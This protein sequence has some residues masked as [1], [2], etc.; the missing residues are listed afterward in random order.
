MK[1]VTVAELIA[2]LQTKPQHL[3]VCFAKYSEYQLL[4]LEKNDED[5]NYIQIKTLQPPRA[6]GWVHND[7]NDHELRTQQY[8]VFPGN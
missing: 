3:P 8:L 2:F 7:W 6:D 5:N 4:E 1:P